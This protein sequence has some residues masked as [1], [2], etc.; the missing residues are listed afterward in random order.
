MLNLILQ[1]QEEM[2][3]SIAMTGF[4]GGGQLK[5]LS[6]RGFSVRFGFTLAEVLITLGI[7]GVV[8][9]MT[10][11]AL[12]QKQNDMQ[13]VTSLKKNYSILSQ[14]LIKAQLQYGFFDTWDYDTSEANKGGIPADM[15]RVFEIIKP[16]LKVLKVCED[17]AGCWHKGTTKDLNGKNISMRSSIGIGT[18]ILIFKLADGTNISMDDHAISLSNFGINY[19]KGGYVFW[20]DANGDKKPNTIGRDIF[21]FALTKKGLV[22]AGIDSDKPCVND[23]L[24]VFTGVTC[25]AK[26]MQDGKIDY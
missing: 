2:M 9:A 12:I 13:I 11:P 20:I 24:G 7:I 4:T 18:S 6:G 16:E 8:A 22:P 21:V 1:R 14:A 26:V 25:T 17:K 15:K 3:K 23:T 19:N 10:L 5:F